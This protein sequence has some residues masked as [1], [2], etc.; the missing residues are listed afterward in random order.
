M[1][2]DHNGITLVL[3]AV[4]LRDYNETGNYFD[5][6]LRKPGGFIIVKYRVYYC[7]DIALLQVSSL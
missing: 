3:K 7:K 5:T 4:G 6:E 1:I 2:S